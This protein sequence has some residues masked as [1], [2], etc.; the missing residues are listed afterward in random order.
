MQ[1]GAR[2]PKK[3]WRPDFQC[4]AHGPQSEV[5][6]SLKGRIFWVVDRDQPDTVLGLHDAVVDEMRWIGG[7]DGWMNDRRWTVVCALCPFSIYQGTVKRMEP[8]V[9]VSPLPVTAGTTTGAGGFS[10]LS[11]MGWHVQSGCYG[12]S[13]DK[14]TTTPEKVARPERSFA[15]TPRSAA[16]L[17]RVQGQD[18]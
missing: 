9:K 8:E 5:F 14:C 3:M 18:G 4:Q 10:F 17:A 2:D 12:C 1:D 6:E 13:L 7:T 15:A 11:F 16:R